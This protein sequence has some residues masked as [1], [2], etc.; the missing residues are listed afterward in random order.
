ME[1]CAGPTLPG[2]LG[3]CRDSLQGPRA[4]GPPRHVVT[5]SEPLQAWGG[6]VTASV[7]PRPE[8]A[9]SHGLGGS[10]PGIPRQLTAR[11]VFSPQSISPTLRLAVMAFTQEWV[12]PGA[13]VDAG[14]CSSV[15]GLLWEKAHP[16]ALTGHSPGHPPPW[17]GRRISLF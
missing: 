9:Q 3:K 12:L 6:A 1:R 14:G 2:S 10:A 13:G 7:S 5:S 8:D 4:A 16:M 17:P 11:S 15:S